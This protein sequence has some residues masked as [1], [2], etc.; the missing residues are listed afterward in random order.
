MAFTMRERCLYTKGVRKNVPKDLNNIKYSFLGKKSHY[1][2]CFSFENDSLYVKIIKKLKII[3][4]FTFFFL[5]LLC[6]I[7][8]MARI[9]N[10]CNKLNSNPMRSLCP[11]C[12]HIKNWKYWEKR[13]LDGMCLERLKCP[14]KRVGNK[15]RCQACLTRMGDNKQKRMSILSDKGLCTECKK[16]KYMES[17]RNKAGGYKRCCQTCYLKRVSIRYFSSKDYWKQLLEM[18]TKQDY[19]CVYSGE[20]LVLGAN[21]F[22]DHIV[23]KKENPARYQDISNCHWVTEDINNMKSSLSETR[24]FD[25]CF[26][27]TRHKDS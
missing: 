22:L 1:F 26:S 20:I 24:F 7:H 15:H 8:M 11:R 18:L 2:Y 10:K 16:N 3:T 9:C 5:I 6:I 17:Q 14:N 12:R 21:A 4:F 23:S 27:V 13:L 25:L 19:R